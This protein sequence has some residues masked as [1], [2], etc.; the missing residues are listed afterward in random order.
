M[1]HFLA[2]PQKMYYNIIIICQKEVQENENK[3]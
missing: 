3:Y 2:I 1:T